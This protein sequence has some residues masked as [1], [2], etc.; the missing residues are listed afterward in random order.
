ME[1]EP[2]CHYIFQKLIGDTKIVDVFVAQN[3]G[4]P[5]DQ[6]FLSFRIDH[7]NIQYHP[8]CDDFGP[9]N[10]ACTIRFIEQLDQEMTA[11][12]KASCRQLVL[13]VGGGRRRLTNATMLLGCYLI[14][15]T[16]MTPE[17]VAEHFSLIDPGRLEDFRDATYLPVDF[18]LT[19]LDCWGGLFQGKQCGWVDRPSEA[20][21]PLWGSIDI[22][23][24]AHYDDPRNGD[25]HQVVP[26]KLIA[27]RGPHDLGGALYADDTAR[28]V[29][30]FSPAFYADLLRD[31]GV[32]D[33]VQLSEGQYDPRAYRAAGI[34]HHAI[35]F[36]DCT[37]PP[38]PLVAKFL[39]VADAAQGAVA[40][41]CKAGLGRTGTLI[42]VWMMRAHGF[43]ARTAMGW[44]R[45]M[46]PGSVIGPQQGFLC[47]VQRIREEHAAARRA[48]SALP[49]AASSSPS[50]RGSSVRDSDGPS[51]SAFRVSPPSQYSESAPPPAGLPSP[52][53]AVAA[54]QVASAL[55]RQGAARMRAGRAPRHTG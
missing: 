19:L 8:Y 44:L 17:R 32:S 49:R 4:N 41:H 51:G 54:G 3:G 12:A 40:V 1:D 6:R 36:E 33:V 35:V 5:N 53:S 22:E 16:E 38:G 45:V 55:D 20:G 47:R 2:L 29:R 25:L 7:A 23:E 27:F 11:C 43:T 42:A 21:S 34:R 24:Y 9:M 50:T 10:M 30:R 48:G 14:V 39:A 37:E 26:G 15:K 46:R 18:G 31:L 13:S 52:T 28:G